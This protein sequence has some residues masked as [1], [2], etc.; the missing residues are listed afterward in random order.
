MPDWTLQDIRG[1]LQQGVMLPSRWAERHRCSRIVSGK[2]EANDPGEDGDEERERPP[3]RVGRAPADDRIEEAFRRANIP[4]LSSDRSSKDV[5]P[6]LVVDIDVVHLVSPDTIVVQIKAE[7][8]EAAHPLKKPTE[9]AWY[10]TW[11]RS[12]RSQSTKAGLAAFIQ[13]GTR[14]MVRSFVELYVRAHAKPK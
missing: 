14:G 1:Y 7:L 8:F 10:S 6:R 3:I 2:H 12:L 11:G 5:R 4:I 9:I 13:N